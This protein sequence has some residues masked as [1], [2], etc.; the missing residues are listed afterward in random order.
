[1]WPGYHWSD[2]T[3]GSTPASQESHAV[4]VARAGAG[5]AVV[6]DAAANFGYVLAPR[7]E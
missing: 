5:V 1:M 6:L 4:V 3:G 2:I 7:V